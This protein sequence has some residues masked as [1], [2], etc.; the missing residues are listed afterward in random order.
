MKTRIVLESLFP[1]YTHTTAMY[2]GVERNGRGQVLVT[3]TD[4]YDGMPGHEYVIRSDGD[5]RRWGPPTVL[6]APSRFGA[7][8]G[9][10]PGIKRLRD[11][12]LMKP[13][14]ECINHDG[15]SFKQRSSWTYV[16]VSEDEGDS[17]VSQGPLYGGQNRLAAT[18][19]RIVELEKGDL[20]LP[21][22]TGGEARNGMES[23]TG[24]LRSTDGGRTWGDFETIAA[25]PVPHIP[26]KPYGFNETSV[27]LLPDGRLIAMLRIGGI[28]PPNEG[29][30]RAPCRCMSSDGG[31]TW[32][33]P[34]LTNIPGNAPCVHVARPGLLLLGY[35]HMSP[36][37][38]GVAASEDDG[39]TW[40]EVA[41]LHDPMGEPK[42]ENEGPA[43]VGYPDIINLDDDR[44]FVVFYSNNRTL[45][46][47]YL[48]GAIL[49]MDK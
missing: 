16:A 14:L 40:T 41:R 43:G 31:R 8:L 47:R 21:L 17:W 20:L 25:T 23:A 5:L 48:G 29:I 26:G 7:G 39:R 18:Y 34:E 44:V 49:R 10:S 45:K 32:S 30:L 3:F 46:H 15:V 28:E 38:T 19:G 22:Y 11:G 12:R 37:Y 9:G 27:A 33:D 6:A 1:V 24:F 4:N 35:R 13:Y 2:P 42:Q 36:N